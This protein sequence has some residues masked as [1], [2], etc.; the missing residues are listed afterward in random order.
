[1][2]DQIPQP[3]FTGPHAQS[4]MGRPHVVPGTAHVYVTADGDYLLNE[5]RPTLR[6]AAAAK[7]RYDVDVTERQ[8]ELDGEDL[9]TLE[10]NF[11]FRYRISLSWQVHDPVAIVRRGITSADTAIRRALYTRMREITAQHPP[12]AWQAAERALNGRFAGGLRLES[13][14]TVLEFAAQ[15]SLDPGLAAFLTTEAE[16]K[17]RLSIDALNRQAVEAALQG[18]DMGILVEHLT[19]NSESTR[20][21]LRILIESRRTS[22]QERRELFRALIEK[23]VLQDVD[24]ERLLESVMPSGTG[25]SA[26]TGGAGPLALTGAGGPPQVHASPFS[27]AAVPLAAPAPAQAAGVGAAGSPPPV[28]PASSRPAGDPPATAVGGV[29]AWDDVDDEEAS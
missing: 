14:I 8:T 11:F 17:G 10:N 13:G 5:R 15:L 26:V 19:K 20:D 21:V 24:L 3:L 28:T 6:Q 23:G 2:N 9:P 12:R 22:E 29:V 7:R 16:T 1:M 25:P 4:G 18:G 27:P